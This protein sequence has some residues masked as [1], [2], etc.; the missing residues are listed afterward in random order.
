MTKKELQLAGALLYE[1]EGPNC[2]A[3]FDIKI[4]IF[5]QLNLQIQIAID[6]LIS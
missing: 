4:R 2:V 3:I 6:T 5:M 1:C